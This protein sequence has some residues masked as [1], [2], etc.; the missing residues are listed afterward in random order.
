MSSDLLQKGFQNHA[1]VW[2]FISVLLFGIINL[3]DT[4]MEHI[5]LCILIKDSFSQQLIV[6]FY[7]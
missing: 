3:A 6:N 2:S 1:M 5:C 4:E 7:L